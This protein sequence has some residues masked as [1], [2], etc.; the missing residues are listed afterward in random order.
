MC[1]VGVTRFTPRQLNTHTAS[2]K[3]KECASVVATRIK[4]NDPQSLIELA[5]TVYPL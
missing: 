1:P 5:N 2:R 3:W 4:T